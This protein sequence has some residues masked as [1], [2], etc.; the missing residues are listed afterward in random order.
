MEIVS[1]QREYLEPGDG[2]GLYLREQLPCSV[3]GENVLVVC[4]YVLKSQ[5][6]I[7]KKYS[8]I[9]PNLVNQCT[10]SCILGITSN[11]VIINLHSCQGGGSHS[12]LLVVSFCI[13]C[14]T[15]LSSNE[16]NRPY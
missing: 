2:P 1:L 8:S 16:D 6:K 14:S 5:Y 15:S 9:L 4:A 3:W 13:L 11:M 12:K 7:N 10:Y